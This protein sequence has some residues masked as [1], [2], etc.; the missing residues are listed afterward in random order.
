MGVPRPFAF[1][2]ATTRA[3]LG[4]STCIR[5]LT[6]QSSSKTTPLEKMCFR[7]WGLKCKGVGAAA[8]VNVELQPH[9]TDEGDVIFCFH[10]KK[11]KLLGA[12]SAPRENFRFPRSQ[13]V[14]CS[15]GG[16]GPPSLVLHGWLLAAAPFKLRLGCCTV[17][18]FLLC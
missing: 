13:K 11:K 9:F 18:L 16:C 2:L 1:G 3:Q 8:L 4:N 17:I 12:R 14:S 10:I 7:P 15:C 6:G 5:G